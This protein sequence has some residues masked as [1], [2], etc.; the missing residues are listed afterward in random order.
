M[1][2]DCIAIP[3]GLPEF[4]VLWTA[5]HGSIIEIKVVKR[6][7]LAICPKCGRITQ[8]F[9]DDRVDDVWDVPA[10]DKGTKL[11]VVKRRWWCDNPDCQQTTPFTEGFD[12]L[13]LGQHRT[14]RLNAHIYR[15]TKRMSNAEVARELAHYQ[16][17]ISESTV[18]RIHQALAQQEVDDRS[19][20]RRRVIGIDEFSIKKRH[21]YATIITDLINRDIVNTF[22][23]RDKET[24][25]KHL[26]QLLYKEAIEAAV[27]DMS[28][29]FRS[30][31]RE[32]LPD[33]HI[34]IDKFHVVGVVIDALDEVR[35]RVQRSKAKGQKKPIYKLRYRLRKGREKLSGEGVQQ[36]WP[37][38]LQEPELLMAYLLKEAFRD[39]YRL[40]DPTEAAQRLEYWCAWAEASGLPEMA[41]AVKTVRNWQEEILNYF[42][43][44]Y[45]NAFTEGKN[46]KIKLIKRQGYGYGNFDSLRL[47]ILTQAA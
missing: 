35:K 37:I 25:V 14:H 7:E 28:R 41:E 20:P 30:A 11:L 44:R 12:S 43:W 3:L 1:Q 13:D 36:L 33:C 2:R 26:N 15:L 19:T 6:V 31:I 16:I 39:W 38:L 47:R 5:E 32:V 34:V 23:K 10:L 22:E 46:N 4:D 21:T 40:Q 9:H 18:R 29:T 27:I 8:H 42:T 45:T 24:V 17:P